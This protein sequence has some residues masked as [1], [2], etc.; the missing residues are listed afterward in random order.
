MAR[1]DEPSELITEFRMSPRKVAARADFE[2][3][4]LSAWSRCPWSGTP[5][6]SIAEFNLKK[7]ELTLVNNGR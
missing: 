3:R 7:C 6:P 2:A 4:V 5:D 1:L